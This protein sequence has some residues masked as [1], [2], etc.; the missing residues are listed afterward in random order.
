MESVNVN[1]DE[2]IEVHE[3]EPMKEIEEYKSFL[4]FY[5]GMLTEEDATNHA[6]I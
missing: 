3:V 1:F 2:Y 4:Y 6:T 5:E